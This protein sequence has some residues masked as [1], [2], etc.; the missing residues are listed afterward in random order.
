MEKYVALGAMLLVAVFLGV[1][2]YL[3]RDRRKY[4]NLAIARK[5]EAD[6]AR[7]EVEFLKDLEIG[8]KQNAKDRLDSLDKLIADLDPRT[9]GVDPKT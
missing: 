4:K 9:G 5:V 7:K 6:S 1:V 8:G 3:I 2:L